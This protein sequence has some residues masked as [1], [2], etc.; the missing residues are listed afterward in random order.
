MSDPFSIASGS[1][2]LVSLGLTLCK[3]LAEYISAVKSHGEDVRNLERKLNT[4][5]MFL[6][7]VDVTLKD[8]VNSQGTHPPDDVINLMETAL[9]YSKDGMARL[10]GY[11]EKCSGEGKFATLEFDE[12]LY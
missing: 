8:L 11:L 9:G 4:L 5:Q 2:G 6:Q 10:K 1:A 3:G 12:V 7:A